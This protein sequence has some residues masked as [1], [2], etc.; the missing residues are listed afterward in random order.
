MVVVV[1]VG[2]GGGGEQGRPMILPIQGAH[3]SV[4]GGGE[5]AG[6]GRELRTPNSLQSQTPAPLHRQ[7]TK[8]P[9]AN[10]HIESTISTSRL[11]QRHP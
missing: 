9:P 2:V 5:V 1:V 8:D 10:H 4:Q 11:L 3:A 7:M 6:W